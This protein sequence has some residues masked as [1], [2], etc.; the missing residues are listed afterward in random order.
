MFCLYRDVKINTGPHHSPCRVRLGTLK[1]L[2]K[3]LKGLLK[4]L[5]VWR[6]SFAWRCI[7]HLSSPGLCCLLLL[8]R[9]ST[10]RSHFAESLL[11]WASALW[12]SF[13]ACYAT[14]W[15]FTWD[16]LGTILVWTWG[17][18]KRPVMMDETSIFTRRWV[19]GKLLAILRP[20]SVHLYSWS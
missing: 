1:A 6:Q 2:I 16:F 4:P 15:G 14:L 13:R 7:L 19:V 12:T 11:Y 10:L 20:I 18:L 8:F 17:H 9:W 3:T 5:L